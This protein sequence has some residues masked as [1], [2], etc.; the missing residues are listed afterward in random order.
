MT[1]THLVIC[2][3][4]GPSTFS[5]NYVARHGIFNIQTQIH[6]EKQHAHLFITLQR[7]IVFVGPN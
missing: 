2:A 7:S 3:I 6:F 1:V 5:F 4:S